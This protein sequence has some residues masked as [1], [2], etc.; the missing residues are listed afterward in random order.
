MA[1]GA[2]HEAALHEALHPGDIAGA[3]RYG[4]VQGTR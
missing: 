2:Q 3:I 1:S 4:I